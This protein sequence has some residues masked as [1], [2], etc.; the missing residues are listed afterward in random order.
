M[1]TFVCILGEEDVV[2]DVYVAAAAIDIRPTT[3]DKGCRENTTRKTTRLVCDVTLPA[4]GVEKTDN[5]P[6]G[7]TE[8]LHVP[9]F[10][11]VFTSFD[12]FILSLEKAVK[13]GREIAISVPS[14]K[15]GCGDV[16]HM[17]REQRRAV[18]HKAASHKT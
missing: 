18:V 7:I 14:S 13:W 1:E 6:I 2:Y 16:Y 12:A 15:G 17:R 8:T 5:L 3:K 4:T 10:I 11:M 9:R